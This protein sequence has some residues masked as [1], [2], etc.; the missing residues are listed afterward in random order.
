MQI[1]TTRRST[2]T[3]DLHHGNRRTTVVSIRNSSY[4]IFVGLIHLINQKILENHLVK[5]NKYLKKLKLKTIYLM[6]KKFK[7]KEL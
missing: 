2:R 3:F 5:L 7:M 1:G 4:R 6:L